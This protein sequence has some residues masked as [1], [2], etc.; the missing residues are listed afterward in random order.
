MEKSLRYTLSV[1][2]VLRSGATFVPL[3]P[4]HPQDRLQK[5]IAQLDSRLVISTPNLSKRARELCPTA[6][7]LHDNLTAE[8]AT[9][10]FP[11]T[12]DGEWR[13]KVTQTTAAYIIFTSGSTGSPK[14]VVIEHGAFTA[15]ALERGKLTGLKP[16][17]RVLQFASH[18]FDVSVDEILT[19]LIHGGC[20]CV[21]TE[22]DR[23]NLSNAISSLRV[24]HALL[25]PSSIKMIEPSHVPSLTALQLGGELIPDDVIDTW[26]KHLRLFN[27]YGPT[28]A[29]VACIMSERS[30]ATKLPGN[31]IGHA[32]ASTCYIVDAENHHT[33]LPAGN[34]GELVI[35]GRILAREYYNDTERTRASFITGLAW[36]SSPEERFYKTGDLAEMTETGSTRIHGRKDNQLKIMGQRINGEEI[37]SYLA[38]LPQLHSAVIDLP[39]QGC[40]RQNLV[41]LVVRPSTQRDEDCARAAK[42]AFSEL[43]CYSEARGLPSSLVELLRDSLELEF[44]RSMIPHHWIELP[45][46]PQNSS[47]KIDRKALR[48]WLATLSDSSVLRLPTES[49]QVHDA[50]IVEDGLGLDSLFR[51]ILC[52]VLWG[53][54]DVQKSSQLRPDVSFIRNGGDSIMAIELR[55]LAR[56]AGLSLRVQDILSNRSLR[57]LAHLSNSSDQSQSNAHDSKGGSSIEP[58]PLSPVQQFFFNVVGDRPNSF[59][60]S[61]A[62]EFNQ[63]LT[64]KALENAIWTLVAVH[65]MLRARFLCDA[66][67]KWTQKIS[68]H[69]DMS[70]YVAFHP[71]TAL[72]L[73]TGALDIPAT[74]DVLLRVFA[75]GTEQALKDL[76]IVAHHLVID[77]VSWRVILQDLENI[78]L[79]KPIDQPTTSFQ[80]WCVL[81]KDY[82]R[83]LDSTKVLPIRLAEENYEYWY[84]KQIDTCNALFNMHGDVM[85]FT[86]CVNTSATDILLDQSSGIKPVDIMIAAFYKAFASTFLDRETPNMYIESH[87]RESWTDDLDVSNTVG[88]FTSAYPIHVP[89]CVARDFMS[90]LRYT[91]EAQCFVPNNG[92][93]YWCHRFLNQ[94]PFEEHH[95]ME[96]VFNFT[97]RFRQVDRADSLFTRL[98]PVGKETAHPAAPRLSLLE[99]LVSVENNQLQ[100]TM[101][102]PRSARQLDKIQQLCSIW[103]ETLHLAASQSK[104]CLNAISAPLSLISPDEEKCLLRNNIT[105]FRG[106]ESVYW[107]SDIQ[108]HML[109]SQAKGASYYWVR[110]IW[111]FLV[112]EKNI[113]GEVDARRL[114][115]AWQRVVE[116]HASLRTAFVF[117]EAAGGHLAVVRRKWTI[118]A[119]DAPDLN[120][121]R[122]HQFEVVGAQGSEAK[123]RLE[124]SHAI[125]DAGSRSTLLEDL[126]K[127]YLLGGKSLS[128]GCDGDYYK[129]YLAK[130]DRDFLQK[131]DTDPTCCVITPD[132]AS[133]IRSSGNEHKSKTTA[134][135]CHIHINKSDL[136]LEQGVT[137]SSLVLASW[138]LVLSQ[139]VSNQNVAFAYVSSE[140]CLD[141]PQIEGAVGLFV[142][143]FV[144]N[145][146]IAA[147]T[148]LLRLVRGIQERHIE[149]SLRRGKQPVRAAQNAVNGTTAGTINTMVN[150]RNSGVDSLR[151]RREN[152]EVSM[153]SFEDSWNYD[154]VL[155]AD[156][157]SDGSTK[158]SIQYRESVISTQL[159][160][161]MARSLQIIADEFLKNSEITLKAI[162]ASAIFL[163]HG[164]NR[165]HKRMAYLLQTLDKYE[166]SAVAGFLPE[167]R[168]LLKLEDS[169]YEPWESVASKLPQLIRSDTLR[170][171]IAALPVL[172][173]I[174]LQS[175]PNWQ[176]AYVVLG[177]IS[178]AF[179]FHKH[180]PAQILPQCIAQPLMDVATHLGLP[181]IATYAGQTIWNHKCGSEGVPM[182]LGS[183]KTCTSFTGSPEESAFFCISVAI[184]AAGAPLIRLLL[185]ANEAAELGDFPV[186]TELLH[187]AAEVISRMTSIL[188]EM[189]SRCSPK[190]FYHTLRPFLEGTAGLADV[191]LP[192]GIKFQ[193]RDKNVYQKFRGPSNA[194]SALFH[195]VDVALGI[196]HIGNS[197]LEELSYSD[198]DAICSR[199]GRL[200]QRG[201]RPVEFL[202]AVRADCFHMEREYGKPELGAEDRQ[203]TR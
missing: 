57:E 177:F 144:L 114:Q 9:G 28:E 118:Q 40:F 138:S 12:G 95:P 102:T 97:G 137:V 150:I 158:C 86:F 44:P 134:S 147:T 2:A 188:P 89:A 121:D 64:L 41:A 69:A 135:I 45:F 198:R 60:Q 149:L 56:D 164:A 106:I 38:A 166:V 18:A 193:L 22:E 5:Q 152:V 83:S 101:T 127:S 143:L 52:R 163:G 59:V 49:D 92:H 161:K 32:V 66:M 160:A 112:T 124:F 13:T 168:P 146:D 76:T 201:T 142:D 132:S 36:A 85:D 131:Q 109:E 54:K 173:T 117:D 4:S 169:Y 107:A 87:G 48:T 202:K 26:S 100:F 157:A 104:A 27:V 179:L 15:S 196:N 42:P 172:D 183:L 174:H 123:F 197:F 25:T 21:P 31:I 94:E 200:E 47:S 186:L 65:P 29:S 35:G 79:S 91:H 1:V 75:S 136:F 70:Q 99:I 192:H 93:P 50:P 159:A 184:E 43:S 194:Q 8:Y 61:V 195:F 155:A 98:S 108:N 46:L 24:N 154:V 190:F 167:R 189:Y 199:A 16:G 37:E 53:G 203:A 165:S 185:S 145:L 119:H 113:S 19:T 122:L 77:L 140:R 7:V 6:L 130:R 182:E 3:D 82:S 20:V 84:P 63:P 171:E 55:R 33:L 148:T 71:G 191:G 180:P 162:F 80:R 34:V 73:D 175:E 58:F 133:A 11:V 78:L 176:R 111:N 72:N 10:P 90:A 128:S 81:Q 139:H 116:H 170:A 30:S 17:S 14:G 126:I 105:D 120:F 62:L 39:K 187:D 141:I 74:A 151:M 115:Q 181:C 67:G 103:H 110:G 125:V 96:V 153:L 68:T 178:N 23:F 51:D 156:V 129:S 88:W